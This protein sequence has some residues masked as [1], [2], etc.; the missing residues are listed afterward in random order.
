MPIR[1][2]L[3]DDHPI[4]REGLAALLSTRPNFQVV[5]EAKNGEEAIALARQLGP[6]L[7]LMD[8]NMPGVNGLE[9]TRRI[10]EDL[11]AVRVVIL[12]L[13]NIRVV[14]ENHAARAA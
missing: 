11:P 13:F 9:A 12:F 2:V 1:L 3:A 14:R 7:V 10:R 8:I 5:G 4:F 6:D